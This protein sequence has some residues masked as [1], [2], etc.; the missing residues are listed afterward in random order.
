VNRRSESLRIDFEPFLDEG[1]RAFI[2]DG[3]NH[4]NVARTG[5]AAYFPS[6]FI[7]RSDRGEVLGGLLGLIW[8]G[9]LHVTTLWVADAFRGQGYGGDLLEAA[10]SHARERGCIGVFLDT[11][12]FQA[13]PFYE[14]QGYRIFGTLADCPPGHESYFLSKRLN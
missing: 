9:W 11:F 1:I 7:L 14:R 10:E 12:G 8:G 6:H 5:L 2:T 13:R 3:V 4:H